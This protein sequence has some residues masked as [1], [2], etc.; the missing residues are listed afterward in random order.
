MDQSR[1]NLQKRTKRI[2]LDFQ[3]LIL[4]EK[5]GL[6]DKFT[7]AMLPRNLHGLLMS[8]VALGRTV[9]GSVGNAAVF[10]SSDSVELDELST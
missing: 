6:K 3:K 4:L 8:L 1:T 2:N 5:N 10:S 7:D 9:E